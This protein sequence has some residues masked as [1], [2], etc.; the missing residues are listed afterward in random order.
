MK[1]KALKIDDIAITLYKSKR[2]K[3]M[4]ISLKPFVGVRV[5]VPRLTP[6]WMAERFVTSRIDWIKSN[7][8]KM[9]SIENQQTIFTEESD[10]K[11]YSHSLQIRCIEVEKISVRVSSGVISIT[12]PK[13]INV[14]NDT[15]Q[16]E[17]RKG[18]ER[19]LRKEAKEYLPKRLKEL[20]QQSNLEFKA[21]AIKN[22]KTRWG[23]CS[24]QNNINLNLHLMRLPNRLIDYVILHELAHTKVKNHSKSFWDF[25]ESILPNSKALDRE[26]KQYN[27]KIY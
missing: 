17:V 26:M 23:S 8:P 5:S 20:A 15:V 13:N 25:L 12:Y 16:Q 11:T 10:F 4:S 1:E 7:L 22:T 9:E 19:A 21:V 18:I 2:A 14:S 6:F 27:T 3:R 24:H